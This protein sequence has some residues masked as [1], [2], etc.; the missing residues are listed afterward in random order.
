[1]TLDEFEYA[2]E[3][4]LRAVEAGPS[5]TDWI[6]AA[7]AVVTAVVA[8]VAIIYARGQLKEASAAR[9]QAKSLELE[10]SQPYVVVTMEGVDGTPEILNLVIRNYGTTIARDVRVTIEP[11]PQSSN[12]GGVIQEVGYPDLIPALAPG[13]HWSTVWDFGRYRRDTTLPDM[14]TG[15]VTYLGVN[16]KELSTDIVLDWSIYKMRHWIVRRGV[17]DIAEAVRDIRAN[18]KKWTESASRGGLKV[19][20]RDGHKLDKRAE[21]EYKKRMKQADEWNAHQATAREAIEFDESSQQLQIEEP[22]RD[23]Q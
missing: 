16:G 14:H 19:F 8:V 17:H 23:L 20:S 5:L 15:S 1:M 21:R 10:K 12:G 6:G 11:K 4:L 9:E 3:R 13:Q 7:A 18:Q 22:S 2:I